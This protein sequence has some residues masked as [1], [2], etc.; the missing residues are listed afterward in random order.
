MSSSAEATDE[1]VRAVSSLCPSESDL[2]VLAPRTAL[3][4]DV[5]FMDATANE[6]RG[7]FIPL[8]VDVEVEPDEDA[9]VAM[10]VF[11]RT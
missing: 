7:C 1:S 2:S 11:V 10:L 5:L 6:W 9:N 8:F 4:T 3:S